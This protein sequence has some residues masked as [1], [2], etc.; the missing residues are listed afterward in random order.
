M[1]RASR[2]ESLSRAMITMEEVS[3]YIGAYKIDVRLPSGELSDYKIF[4]EVQYPTGSP[5]L[6]TVRF[7]AGYG[8]FQTLMIARDTDNP[9]AL[10]FSF[11]S[12]PKLGAS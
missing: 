10:T 1:R 9:S 4:E 6:A 8:A 11:F 2:K 3:A 7:Q 5:D 12:H